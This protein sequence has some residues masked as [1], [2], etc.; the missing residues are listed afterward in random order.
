M[1]QKLFNQLVPIGSQTFVVKA[2]VVTF[3]AFA[4]ASCSTVAKVVPGADQLWGDEDDQVA[5]EDGDFPELSDTPEKPDTKDIKKKEERLTKDLVGDV[6][7][8]KHT[9]EV[10]TGAEG[11]SNSG[12][13][14]YQDDGPG[15]LNDTDFGSFTPTASAPANTTPT[16]IDEAQD[17][18]SDSTIG[19]EAGDP[20]QDPEAAATPPE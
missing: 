9:R 8:A 14:G 15:D 5:H 3:C 12:Q 18:Q 16:V 6:E 1:P 4:L 20:T 13:R 19:Y 10:I 2:V 11:S 17:Q 7:H